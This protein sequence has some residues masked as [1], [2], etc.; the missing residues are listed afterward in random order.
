[1]LWCIVLGASAKITSFVH[2]FFSLSSSLA[3]TVKAFYVIL[4]SAV[5][6]FKRLRLLRGFQ[7]Q[8][9]EVLC[10]VFFFLF[11]STLDEQI[12]QLDRRNMTYHGDA[13]YNEK[14]K[15]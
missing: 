9:V 7:P 6:L 15:L 14:P 4:A 8:I 10:Y 12:L 5:L 13:R 11:L 1:M 3:F 2:I